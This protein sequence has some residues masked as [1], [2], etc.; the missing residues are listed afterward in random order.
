VRRA[1][2]EWE[3][4]C[5]RTRR[6]SLLRAAE[7]AAAAKTLC[8]WLVG[9][10]ADHWPLEAV[11]NERA[12]SWPPFSLVVEFGFGLEALN[13]WSRVQFQLSVRLL[14]I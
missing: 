9:R 8:P 5:D 3:V 14:H 2:G 10:A 12:S 6:T 7:V 11:A 1:V 4:L 13:T